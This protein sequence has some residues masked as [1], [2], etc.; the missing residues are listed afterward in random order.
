MVENGGRAVSY[1]E[2]QG[3]RVMKEA[4]KEAEIEMRVTLAAEWIQRPYGHAISPTTT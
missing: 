2:E 4:M 3:K 1:T